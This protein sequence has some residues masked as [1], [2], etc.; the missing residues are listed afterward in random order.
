MIT[1]LIYDGITNSDGFTTT[2]TFNSKSF[3]YAEVPG[4][5]DSWEFDAFLQIITPVGQR[6]LRTEKLEINTREV[7]VLPK[8]IYDSGLD[9]F[10][11]LPTDYSVHLKV[12]A[13]E[14]D[15]NADRVV[16]FTK[17]LPVNQSVEITGYN[18]IILNLFTLPLTSSF[19]VE[20]VDNNNIVYFSGNN[21]FPLV[22]AKNH[23]VIIT[24]I[25]SVSFDIFIF[26]KHCSTIEE[27]SL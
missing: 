7:L 8:Q 5:T 21:D 17:F 25:D 18:L 20:L 6:L 13:V 19:L 26:A 16:K 3:V 4:S 24:N 1:K 15:L 22:L 2:E 10:F 23:K 27:I 11:V 9:C 12:W 14:G